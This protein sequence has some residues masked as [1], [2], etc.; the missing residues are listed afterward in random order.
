MK[1]RDE[2]LPEHQDLN[3]VLRQVHDTAELPAIRPLLAHLQELL[4]RHFRAE[5]GNDGL[6]DSIQKRAPRLRVKV[7][8]CRQEH[9]ELLK[10]L[11]GLINQTFVMQRD[12]KRFV[13]QLRDHEAKESELINDSMYVD[14]G[15]RG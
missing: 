1:Q 6:F 11:K 14:L 3:G 10:F 4:R 13:Q 9:R 15:G 2:E 5:E 12:A 7:E 8:E